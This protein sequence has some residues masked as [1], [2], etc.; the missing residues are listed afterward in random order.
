MRTNKKQHNVFP[1]EPTD[2]CNHNGQRVWLQSITRVALS[3]TGSNHLLD[4]CSSGCL[5][6]CALACHVSN[7]CMSTQSSIQGTNLT[8]TGSYLKYFIE[9]PSCNHIYVKRDHCTG[10]RAGPKH[11][12]NH[13]HE[14]ALGP[15]STQLQAYGMHSRYKQHFPSL[16]RGKLS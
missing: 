16:Y 9:K 11:D 6:E 1:Q 10:G 7:T 8:L 13:M 4:Q 15:C 14:V 12:S 3:Y 2:L 5:W